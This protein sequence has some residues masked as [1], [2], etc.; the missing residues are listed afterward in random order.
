MFE[1]N[2]SS[3]FLGWGRDEDVIQKR[4]TSPEFSLELSQGAVQQQP[5]MYDLNGALIGFE[6]PISSPAVLSKCFS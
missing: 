1:R 4:I 2:S 5:G 3:R 6:N